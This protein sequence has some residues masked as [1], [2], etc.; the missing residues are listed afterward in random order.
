MATQTRINSKKSFPVSK[1]ICVFIILGLLAFGGYYFYKYQDLNKKYQQAIESPEAKVKKIVDQISK[2][3]NIPAFDK[4]KPTIPGMAIEGIYT[5]KEEELSKIKENNDFFK[6]ANKDDILVAYKDANLSII[7]RPSENRIIKVGSY[8]NGVFVSVKIAVLGDTATAEK[9]KATLKS[10]FPNID[11]DV[12]T[13]KVQITKGFIVD[14]SGTEP[15]AAKQL[16]EAL[17]YEVGP[18]PAGEQAP[19]GAKL[20]IIAPTTTL[21]P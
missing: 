3:Y 18:L 20:V 8:A 16:A 12:S 9:I 2:L 6:D 14:V 19:E 11:V 1:V 21:A 4:E 17:G 5:L 13:P 7:Y 10:K 15:E